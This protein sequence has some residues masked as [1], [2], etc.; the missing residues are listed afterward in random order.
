[1]KRTISLL[2]VAA[3]LLSCMLICASTASASTKA[4]ESR[5]ISIVFDNSGSMYVQERMWWS[6]A[7]YAMEVFASM[8]NDGDVLQIYPMWPIDVKGKTYTI[9]VKV[10]SAATAEY[11]EASKTIKLKIKVK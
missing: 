6:Q 4:G 7:M 2:L 10:T 8:L 9:R 5:A 1:M 11:A 3:V